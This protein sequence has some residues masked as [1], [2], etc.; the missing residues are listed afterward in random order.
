[1]A[2]RTQN[3]IKNL[4]WGN[5]SQ[6]THLVLKFISRTVFI[7][8][9]GEAY[10]GVNGLYSNVLGVL[11]FAEL[12]IGT[13]M[14]FALYKPVADDD[15]EKIK[16]LMNFYK[17][18]YRIIALIVFLAG[19]AVMPFLGVLIKEPGD[20]GNIYLYYLIFL[21][22][23]A[24][25]YLVTYK[26]SLVSAEQKNYIVTNVNTVVSFIQVI[27][28]ITVMLAY[29]S[30]LLYLLAN[31]MVSLGHKIFNTVYLNKKYPYLNEPC[32]KLDQK[33]YHNI[34]KNV[35]ALIIHKIGDV[36][37][38]QTDNILIS[39]FISIAVVGKISNYN[40]IITTVTGFL[41]VIF[42]SVIGSLGNLIASE[43]K[44]KQYEIFKIYRFVGFWIY[45][46]CAIAFLIL[47][48]P[49]IAL[50]AGREWLVD[51]LTVALICLER[52]NV[53]HRV[54]V[55]NYKSAAGIFD[56]DKWVA[57]GQA[58]IN[59]AV[60]VV[61]VKLI[62][63]SGIYVGTVVQ[64]L[65]CTAIK[66]VILYKNV[67]R[68]NPLKYYIESAKYLGAEISAAVLL[69]VIKHFLIGNVACVTYT[70]FAILLIV[71]AIIPN[72][73]FLGLFYHTNEW[74]YLWNIVGSKII[75]KLRRAN[76]D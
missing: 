14:N 40:Y 43:T 61:M 74:K 8:F 13:A 19:L 53:G 69:L 68:Q 48:Q 42:S 17:K 29:R 20:I 45:G 37:V 6:I 15:R 72:V 10:M 44:E 57:F 56:Q 28:Q 38:H 66:P 71:T 46:F 35:F 51:D 9:L 2:S 18:A 30:F 67:F 27:F 58:A 76:N 55:N 23:T 36:C 73:L 7:Y 60:S 4:L 75:R 32:Q 59:L 64:G 33:E 25:S 16:S 70:N 11:S 22:D 31:L 26:Y 50:W 63:L 52:Y 34:R 21:F 3:T 24:T 12:G 62:G 1:M 65:F 41:S 49:F 5:V 47:F 54:V 39:A